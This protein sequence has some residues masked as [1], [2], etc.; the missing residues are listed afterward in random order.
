MAWLKENPAGKHGSRKYSL[1]ELGLNEAQ[2]RD[3]FS[4]YFELYRDYL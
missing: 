4:E 2:V 3:T 1:D